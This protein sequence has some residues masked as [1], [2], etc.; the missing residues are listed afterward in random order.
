MLPHSIFWLSIIGSPNSASPWVRKLYK[1]SL[2]SNSIVDMK[3]WSRLL[4][5]CVYSLKILECGE[6]DNKG[7]RG[8]EAGP[9]PG[10]LWKLFRVT[11]RISLLGLKF[12]CFFFCYFCS[13]VNLKKKVIR[14]LRAHLTLQQLLR[15]WWWSSDRCRYLELSLLKWLMQNFC[16]RMR[17]L[18]TIWESVS[19]IKVPQKYR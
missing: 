4:F 12:F 13:L 8:F 5:G 14:S 10:N 17:L 19:C 7:N 3:Y 15:F 6:G 16:S 9:D 1:Y 2:F 18:H 11:D